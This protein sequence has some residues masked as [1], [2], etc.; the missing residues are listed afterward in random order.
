VEPQRLLRLRAEM[1]LPG[2][3]WLE[4]RLEPLGGQRTRFVQRAVYAPRG[5]LGHAYWWSVAP[6]HA[7]VFGSMLRNIAAA[8]GR[9]HGAAGEGSRVGRGAG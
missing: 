7:F 1:R 4:W 9:A 8:A 3:A 2:A 6:F 5:L